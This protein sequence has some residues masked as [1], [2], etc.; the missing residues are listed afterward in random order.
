MQVLFLGTGSTKWEVYD[1]TALAGAPPAAPGSGLAGYALNGIN[2]GA[3][4]DA[5]GHVHGLE[6][7]KSSHRHT[8]L[9]G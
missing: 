8:L 6:W 1:Q 3:Y 9:T 5:D 2:Y 7:T 4:V